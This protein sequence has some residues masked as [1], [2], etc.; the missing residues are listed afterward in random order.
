MTRATLKNDHKPCLFIT[1]QQ[2]GLSLTA[3]IVMRLLWRAGI[4]ALCRQF[5]L[6]HPRGIKLQSITLNYWI[7]AFLDTTIQIRFVII[8][9]Y[10]SQFLKTNGTLE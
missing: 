7:T 5:T 8:Y 4:T 3:E 1:A 9:C 2:G 10:I 6:H